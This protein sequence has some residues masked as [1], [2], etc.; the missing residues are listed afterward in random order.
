[1]IQLSFSTINSCLQPS[2]SHCYI[3]KM[4]GRKIP[5]NEA[6][7]K[8]KE[9]Q[10]YIKAH[11]KDFPDLKGFQI[12]GSEMDKE[13]KVSIL[14]KKGKYQLIGYIDGKRGENSNLEVLE[15]KT[16]T[17][18]WPI[19]QFYNSPQIGLYSIM[20]GAK[21]IVAMTALSDLSLWPMQPP[22]MYEID[23]TKK[24]REK[25]EKWLLDAI[26]L[27]E[28]GDFTG[29]LEDGVC[30]GWCNYGNNCFYK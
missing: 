21:K 25:A 30:K 24:M 3:N 5:E 6:M 18:F 29:G 15:I 19:S 8:G 26:E 13:M 17:K 27:Y 22:K 4:L 16:S 14:L 2:N 20:T 23:V 1:M 10:D 12:G 7:K 11:Q 28:R 9:L